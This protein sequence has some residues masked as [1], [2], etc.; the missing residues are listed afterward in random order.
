MWTT[1]YYLRSVK[2]VIQEIEY[3]QS[4]YQI[5]GVQF[6]DLTAVVKKSWIIDFCRSLIDRKIN[7]DWS[8]PSGTRSEALDEEVLSWLARAN[9]KYLVYAPE[10]GS[11]ITLNTIKGMLSHWLLG[12]VN[13]DCYTPWNNC[14]H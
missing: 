5:T 4:K 12:E 8:L 9:L 3:Y 13:S 6:Y 7:I 1:R 2:D 10:S 14:S 11:P